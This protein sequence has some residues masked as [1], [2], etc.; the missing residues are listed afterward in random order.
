MVEQGGQRLAGVALTLIGPC[1]RD[2]DRRLPGVGM[3]KYAAIPNEPVRRAQRDG[4]L[5]PSPRCPGDLAALA[6]DECRRLGERAGF[7][8]LVAGDGGSDR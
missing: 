4:D 3:E 2:A 5:C 6:A 1:Q 7:P 8:I